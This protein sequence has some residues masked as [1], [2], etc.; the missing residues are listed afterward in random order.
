MP[1]GYRVVKVNPDLIVIEDQAYGEPM[2][3]VGGLLT[4]TMD[5]MAE[6]VTSFLEYLGAR[7]GQRGYSEV[8]DAPVGDGL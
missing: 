1:V 7:N 3:V 8:V 5:R 2:V 6:V 4:L